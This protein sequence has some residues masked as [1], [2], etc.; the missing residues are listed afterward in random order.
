MESPEEKYSLALEEVLAAWMEYAIRM[1]KENLK[2][3]KMVFTAELENSLKMRMTKVV[4]GAGAAQLDVKNY[5][6]FRDMKRR[7]YSGPANFDKMLEW[8]QKIG[9][10]KFKFV[11]GYD[12]RKRKV[13]KIPTTSIAMNRIA[14]GIAWSRFV[15][16][17]ARRKQWLN[18]YFYGPLQYNLIESIMEITGRNSVS[19]ITDQ[20]NEELLKS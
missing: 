14:W 1:L 19:I 17:N 10:A 15:K 20:L 5:G 7:N 9:I 4:D 16:F 2:K 3:K 11:P 13:N 18:K 12:S 6:R 8:V